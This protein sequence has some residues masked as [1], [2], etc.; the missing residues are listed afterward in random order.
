[1]ADGRVRINKEVMQTAINDYKTQKGEMVTT[2][3]R[4][5]N[6]V[7]ELDSIWD[8]DAS[9]KFKSRFNEMYK[10]LEQCEDTVN[11]FISNLE[12]VLEN[13]ESTEVDIQG[14]FE[15]LDEGIVYSNDAAPTGGGM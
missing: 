12:T 5:S 14:L 7:R 15:E 9:E 10:N 2:C 3:L 13:Y 8:G 11:Q 4:I 1:M 6:A